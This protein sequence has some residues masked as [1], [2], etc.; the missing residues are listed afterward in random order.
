MHGCSRVAHRPMTLNK[1]YRP[2]QC[3]R[4]QSTQWHSSIL[5]SPVHVT[6]PSVHAVG[7]P[8]LPSLYRITVKKDYSP[9]SV[10]LN[11][12]PCLLRLAV[13]PRLGYGL[14]TLPGICNPRHSCRRIASPVACLWSWDTRSRRDAESVRTVTHSLNNSANQL[15][16]CAQALRSG[17]PLRRQLSHSF[18]VTSVQSADDNAAFIHRIVVAD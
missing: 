18:T 1:A 10:Q 9:D 14:G 12:L 5:R 13:C 7:V 2:R 8:L 11:S 6:C 3:A 4:D 16:A 17:Q 15:N